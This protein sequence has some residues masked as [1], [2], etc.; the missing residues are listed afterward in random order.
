MDKDTHDGPHGPGCACDI[1]YE[2]V[3]DDFADDLRNADAHAGIAIK[4]NERGEPSVAISRAIADD[5][6]MLMKMGLMDLLD[7]EIR[8][9]LLEE[10]TPTEQSDSGF[11]PSDLGVDLGGG[12]RAVSLEEAR[13][14]G[15]LDALKD[16]HDEHADDDDVDPVDDGVSIGFSDEDDDD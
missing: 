9:E 3:R 7:D 15:L 14:S 1:P 2:E 5:L 10:D 4:V 6:P 11:D 8:H 12:A 13:E 16:A